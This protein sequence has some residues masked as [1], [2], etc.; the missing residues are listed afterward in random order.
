MM[1]L[2]LAFLILRQSDTVS[3]AVFTLLKSTSLCTGALFSSLSRTVLRQSSMASLIAVTTRMTMR[4]TA[5]SAGLL[6]PKMEKIYKTCWSVSQHM[7]PRTVKRTPRIIMNKK[8]TLAILWNWNHKFFG[9]KLSGVYFAV[10]IL[11]RA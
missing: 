5:L 3:S 1:P 10:L 8:Y 9:T 7:H 2:V 11:L 4:G 6:A